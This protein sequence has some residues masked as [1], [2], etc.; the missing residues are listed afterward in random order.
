MV[1]KVQAMKGPAC[2]SAIEREI[3]R[4]VTGSPSVDVDL[5]NGEVHVDD[6]ADPQIVSFA[7]DGLGYQ[8]EAT[9]QP[10]QSS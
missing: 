5:E 7:I 1:Y 3:R 2:A 4:Q 9:R 8:V 6:D 10:E